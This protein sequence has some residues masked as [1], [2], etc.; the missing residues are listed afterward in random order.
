MVRG[1]WT[2]FGL[3]GWAFIGDSLD[4]GGGKVGIHDCHRCT[5]L[6]HR[7]GGEGKGINLCGAVSHDQRCGGER[8]QASMT[9]RVAQY[10][11][12]EGGEGKGIIL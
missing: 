12:T 6:C 11:V 9:A 10:C 4:R 5:I 1:N 8:G 3:W 7:R 2:D